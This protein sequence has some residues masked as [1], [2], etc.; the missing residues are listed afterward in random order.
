M[1]KRRLDGIQSRGFLAAY[2][3]GEIRGERQDPECVP[4][5]FG[6]RAREG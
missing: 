5:L 4:S 3:Q 6:I 1:P 2:L